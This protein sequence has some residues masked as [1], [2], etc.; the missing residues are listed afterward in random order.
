[1]GK[2]G[3]FKIIEGSVNAPKGFHAGGL[4]CGLKKEKLDLGWIYSEVPAN[5]TAV[6]TTNLFQAAPIQVTRE[7]LSIQQQLQGLIVNSG[8]A[9]ACTGEPGL[10][11]AY[12]MRRLFAELKHIPEHYVAVASTGLI[13]EQLPMDK[14]KKGIASISVDHEDPQGENFSQAILTTD[15]CPKN[16]AVQV[17][18]DGKLVTIA[19]AAKGSGMIHPNMA[20]MLSFITTDAAIDQSA[21]ASLLKETTDISFN[22]ITVD[23]D[24]STNDMV[25]VLANG[26]A[27]NNSLHSHHP[28]WLAFTLAFTYV[29]QE[30]AK[31]IAR[32][33]EGAT[34]LIEVEVQGASDQEAAQKI[35]KAVVS[36]NL[37]KSAVFGCDPNWGRIICAAGY[38]GAPLDPEQVKVRI[39]PFTV[40]EQGLPASFDREA[41]VNYLKQ[42]EVEIK[43][44]LNQGEGHAVAW[45]CDLTYDYVTIN[46]MYTT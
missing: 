8:N 5:A 18:I 22:S 20:T 12:E 40:V 14:L 23:G 4:H 9:N 42:E 21:L 39:G 45:G 3:Q 41:A 17:D 43:V 33:G 24:T 1:M 13:G 32:D 34:K 37:V 36:S 26:L 44:F 27:E 15:T 38:S 19:G 31:K 16:V 2:K 28:D 46:A 6:Y 30:L 25:L 29:C 10:Q 7:S 35:A 11:N